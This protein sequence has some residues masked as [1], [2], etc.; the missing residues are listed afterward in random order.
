MRSLLARRRSASSRHE[1]ERSAGST[2]VTRWGAAA[3]LRCACVG[4][5]RSSSIALACREALMLLVLEGRAVVPEDGTLTASSAAISSA[6]P[7]KAIRTL[8]IIVTTLQLRA[9]RQATTATAGLWLCRRR[10]TALGRSRAARSDLT[11]EGGRGLV[12]RGVD[13]LGLTQ[14][15]LQR[16]LH[17]C[18]SLQGNHHAVPSARHRVQRSHAEARCEHPIERGWHATSLNV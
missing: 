12:Q 8:R 11:K 2:G 9:P 3:S 13:E 15:L 16:D 1:H 4:R 6:E 17:D 7:A 10:R 14:R 18:W 5:L